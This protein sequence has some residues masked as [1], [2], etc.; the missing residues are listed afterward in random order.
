MSELPYFLSSCLNIA[1][2]LFRWRPITGESWLDSEES[3]ESERYSEIFAKVVW[4]DGTWT[5]IRNHIELET[6]VAILDIKKAWDLKD[7]LWFVLK[8]V[9]TVRISNIFCWP[10][11]RL[12]DP[13][14]NV[15][16]GCHLSYRYSCFLMQT[17]FSPSTSF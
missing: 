15:G 16:K 12:S 17:I 13:P 14:Y 6:T 1:S 3:A 11:K 8:K 7:S 2:H 5:W 4:E 9:A 10:S